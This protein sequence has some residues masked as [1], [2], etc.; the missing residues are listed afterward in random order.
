MS[1]YA[2]TYFARPKNNSHVPLFCSIFKEEMTS[3]CT[4]QNILAFM[5]TA[6]I[7]LI[8]QK[9]PASII[10]NG[11]VEQFFGYV[12][13]GM[14]AI[15]YNCVL[16]FVYYINPLPTQMNRKLKDHF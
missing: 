7:S 9:T 14:H 13:E 5:K 2:F 1:G 16:C 6:P 15:R 3:P 8:L 10:F 11:Y 12:I 4:G